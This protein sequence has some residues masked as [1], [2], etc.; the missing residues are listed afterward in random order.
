MERITILNEHDVDLIEKAVEMTDKEIES[1]M[2]KIENEL[3]IGQLRNISNA[4]ACI[5]NV[6]KIKCCF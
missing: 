1:L 4:M 5:K 3:A 2:K 6:M